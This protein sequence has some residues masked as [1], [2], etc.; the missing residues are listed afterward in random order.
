MATV[1]QLTEMPMHKRGYGLVAFGGHLFPFNDNFFCDGWAGQASIQLVDRGFGAEF[2]F[3]RVVDG[4][5][6][7]PLAL[8]KLIVFSYQILM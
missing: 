5:R 1:K 3:K 7:S 8:E 6:N 4:M 2:S